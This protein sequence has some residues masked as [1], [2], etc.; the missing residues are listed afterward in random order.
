[1]DE[2]YIDVSYDE[3]NGLRLIDAINAVRR[4]LLLCLL[5]GIVVAGVFLAYTILRIEPQYQSSFT[6]YVSNRPDAKD[7]SRE[8]LAASYIGLDDIHASYSLATTY[9]YMIESP[10][11]ALSA[12]QQTG[13]SSYEE[14]ALNRKL[15]STSLEQETPLLTV[16]TTADSPEDAYKISEAILSL[17]PK[18]ISSIYSVGSMSVVEP[19]QMSTEQ[20]S[21][22]NKLNAAIGFLLGFGLSAL[23][24]VARSDKDKLIRDKDELEDCFGIPAFVDAQEILP[25]LPKQANQTVGIMDVQD[26]SLAAADAITLAESYATRGARVLLVDGDTGDASCQKQLGVRQTAGLFDV[27][28]GGAVASEVVLRLSG[29]GIDFMASG[30]RADDLFLK[31]GDKQVASLIAALEREY[32]SV[33]VAIPSALSDNSAL[34]LA[35]KVDKAFLSVRAGKT[36][37]PDIAEVLRRLKLVDV[38]INGFMYSEPQDRVGRLVARHG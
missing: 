11:I 24:V 32:D 9:A 21:P 33:V 4:R 22:S 26:G 14:R 31:T 6:V 3:D 5:A 34:V 17:I 13:L 18:R 16:T 29:R 2:R 7:M 38:R 1:M 35:D 15:V 19:A 12:L 23:V 30:K 25:L 27:L 28:D 20:S 10:D 36:R 8:E 37:K